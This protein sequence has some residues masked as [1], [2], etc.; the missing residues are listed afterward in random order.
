MLRSKNA[1]AVGPPLTQ[2]IHPWMKREKK[3]IKAMKFY[4]G[5]NKYQNF[6][7]QRNTTTY[8]IHI[9]YYWIKKCLII[10]YYVLFFHLNNSLLLCECSSIWQ[11]NKTNKQKTSQVVSW[12]FSFLLF[13]FCF[14][15]LLLKIIT[16]FFKVMKDQRWKKWKTYFNQMS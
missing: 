15:G 8:K 13:C 16:N 5:V 10:V 2:I 7:S 14:P 4:V 12:Q 11:K 9:Q 3:I 1:N 6:F